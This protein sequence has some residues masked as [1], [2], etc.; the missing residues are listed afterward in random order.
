M[1]LTQSRQ[2]PFLDQQGDA[3][4]A[5]IGDDDNSDEVWT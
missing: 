1:N 4:N 5:T 3:V 2:F